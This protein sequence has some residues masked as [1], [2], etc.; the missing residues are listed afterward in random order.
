MAAR[1][2]TWLA[3]VPR[4][5]AGRVPATV[6]CPGEAVDPTEVLRSNYDLALVDEGFDEGLAPES[7]PTST[8]APM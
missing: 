8:I 6:G 5:G 1:S 3:G 7:V 4:P 2:E